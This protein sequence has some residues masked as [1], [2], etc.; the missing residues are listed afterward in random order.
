ME[1]ESPNVLRDLADKFKDKI[2]SGIVVLGAKTDA[3]ALL[4]AVVTKDLLDRYHAGKIIK[5][6]AAEVGG[7][8]GGRPDM[9]QAGGPNT[10]NLEK[11]IEKVYGVVS[12]LK[13]WPLK[14]T[15]EFTEITELFYVSAE[16]RREGNI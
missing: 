9:A 5:A 1:A 4:I 6:V 3:K 7:N 12:G 8:G 13:N 2:Q 14:N 16:R 15:T 11:A 10:E